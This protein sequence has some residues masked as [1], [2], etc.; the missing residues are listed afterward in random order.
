M[1]NNQDFTLKLMQQVSDE[2]EKSNAKIDQLVI[3]QNDLKILIEKQKDQS[4]RQ[5]DVL[6]RHQGKYIKENLESYSDNIKELILSREPVVNETHNSQYI[7]FGKD[8]PFTSKLLLSLITLILIS[9]PL[10]KYVPSYLNERS[11]LKEDLET[12][13]LFYDYVFFINYKTENELPSNLT[14]I[15]NDIKKRDSTYINF[16]N[17]QRSKYEIHLK[18][19]SLKSEL[20]KLQE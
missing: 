5:F 7:L 3:A 13:K 6:T 15:I 20:Q 8:S 14:N 1:S 2:L 19:E 18:R 9:I 4:K 16:V 10:F 17:R 11:V 12:Y